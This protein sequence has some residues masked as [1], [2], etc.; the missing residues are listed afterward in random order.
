MPAW[1]APVEQSHMLARSGDG[2]GGGERGKG[3]FCVKIATLGFLMLGRHAA[4]GTNW[5]R[6]GVGSFFCLCFWLLLG[7]PLRSPSRPGLGTACRVSTCLPH[8]GK[9][10]VGSEGWRRCSLLMCWIWMAPCSY[11]TRGARQEGWTGGGGAGR[12]RRTGGWLILFAGR[13]TGGLMRYVMY[14][15]VDDGSGSRE[16]L[17]FFPSPFV[18]LPIVRC[19]QTGSSFF[20]VRCNGDEHAQPRDPSDDRRSHQIMFMMAFFILRRWAVARSWVFVPV[21]VGLLLEFIND[22]MSCS[23]LRVRHK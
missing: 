19:A 1:A 5:E 20:L 9:E 2:D 7:I 3:F 11:R 14:T 10:V 23:N 13:W 16:L 15:V 17:F 8:L 18:V 4:L 6:R 12:R 22:L 21:L